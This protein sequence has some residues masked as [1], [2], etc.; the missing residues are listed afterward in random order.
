MKDILLFKEI[1]NEVKDYLEKYGGENDDRFVFRK[2]SEHIWR[3][4]IWTK[5]LIEDCTENINRE[6]LLTAALFHDIGYR[7][8]RVQDHGAQGALIFREYA[9]SKNYEKNQADFIEYLIRSH[10]S[11]ICCFQMMRLWSLYIF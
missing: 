2:R 10:S 11:K 9:E 8:K 1:F 5:R 7:F 6:A 4:F 3:V